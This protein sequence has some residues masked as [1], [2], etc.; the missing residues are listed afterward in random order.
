MDEEIIKLAKKF[1]VNLNYQ[2]IDVSKLK[3]DRRVRWKCLFGCNFYGR[4]SCPPHIPEFEECV[5]FVTSYKKAILFKFNISSRGDKVKA[6]RFLLEI[7][8]EL[9]KNYPFVFAV[10]PGGCELCE[11]CKD[12]CHLA[13]P[14]LSALCIDAS[15]LELKENE[16]AGLL[17]LY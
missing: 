9:L 5:K 7:E 8:K 13:R 17:F 11:E 14:S 10:F 3:F 12:V 1:N 4:R 15:N 16:M 6:Q 2:E